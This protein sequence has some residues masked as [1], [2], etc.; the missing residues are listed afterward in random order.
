MSTHEALEVISLGKAIPVAV[1]AVEKLQ[2]DSF[3]KITKIVSGNYENEGE[4]E[5]R[6]DKVRLA[7]HVSKI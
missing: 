2:R 5:F 3:L 1:N 4:K 7:V 6:R